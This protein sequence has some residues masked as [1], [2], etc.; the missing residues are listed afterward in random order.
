[1][2]GK[3]FEGSKEYGTLI[4]RIGLGMIFIYAGGQKLLGMFDGPGISGFAK[5]LEG[6]HFPIPTAMAVV[7]GLAEFLGGL[8]VLAGIITRY[9][10][11]AI[12]SVMLVAIFVVHW[13]TGFGS[14]TPAI[15]CGAMAL[16][17]V[18]SGG[19]KASVD[20]IVKIDEKV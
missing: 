3:W 8:L 20:R 15:A 7:A 19:G 11:L 17:L 1:M 13:K 5:S 6:M 10:A 4:I 12:L 2:I 14:M 9:A 16:S 18:V